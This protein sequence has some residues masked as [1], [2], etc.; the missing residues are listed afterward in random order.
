MR[1]LLD[2]D[3]PEPLLPLLQHLLR[4]HDVSHVRAEAWKSKKDGVLLPDA[5]R[6]GFH[7][8][9]TNDKGQLNNPDECRAIQKSGMHHIR[10]DLANGLDGLAFASASIC[11]AIRPLLADLDAA[12]A[13]RVARIDKVSSG[14]K[15]YKVKN[16]ATD[17]PSPYWP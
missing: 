15:R 2:E 9:L 13:Q 1:L 10:Y 14:R 8:F 16:P 3:V 6:R 4:G 7:A 12:P 17:P 11:A 5:A